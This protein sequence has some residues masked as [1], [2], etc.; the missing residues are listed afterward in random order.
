[1][2]FV[3]DSHGLSIWMKGRFHK[4]ARVLSLLRDF[5]EPFNITN[6][7]P[8]CW[9][10]EQHNPMLCYHF[11]PGEDKQQEYINI[12]TREWPLWVKAHP[13][14]LTRDV[15]ALYDAAQERQRAEE[16]KK[17][18]GARRP[19]K[20]Y[21]TASQK[22]EIKRQ[23]REAK[24]LIAL[25]PAPPIKVVSSDP[26]IIISPPPVCLETD[27]PPC[28]A[29]T[30]PAKP[31]IVA[32][33]FPKSLRGFASGRYQECTSRKSGFPIVN[34]RRATS[35]VSALKDMNVFLTV[36]GKT[37]QNGDSPSNKLRKL[38]GACATSA[39]H[40]FYDVCEDA[41]KRMST[42]TTRTVYRM[43]RIT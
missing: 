41:F 1:M 19:L 29:V 21:L 36:V 37:L 38:L 6:P 17:A 39:E 18:L 3:K 20:V 35:Y 25:A 31:L 9:N 15:K 22:A 32:Y 34:D 11:Y 24:K 2:E 28:G 5:P 14:F 10:A 8:K 42:H 16:A 7:C 13:E 33:R 30:T 23:K 4:R 40:T 43:L 12:V 27:M 26:N